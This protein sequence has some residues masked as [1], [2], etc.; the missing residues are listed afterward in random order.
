MIPAPSGDVGATALLVVRLWPE[1]D[2]LR[3]RVTWVADVEHAVPV[4]FATTSDEDL[5]RFVTRCLFE[6]RRR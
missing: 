2:G 3:A 4:E 5:V 1:A 6:V